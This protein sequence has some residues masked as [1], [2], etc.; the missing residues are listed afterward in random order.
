MRIRYSIGTVIYLAALLLAGCGGGGGGA[1]AAAAPQP[2]TTTVLSGMASK[3]PIRGG[4][5][6][7][8]AVRFGVEDRSAPIGQGRTDDS[9][10]YSIDV[11]SYQG[12]VLVEVTGGMFMDEVSGLPVALNVPLRAAVSN[13]VAG[14]TI[15]AV[16]PLTELAFKRAKGRGSL[17]VAS[18]DDSNAGV[19]AIFDLDDI[20]S[21]LP[22]AGGVSYERKYASACGSISQLVNDNR[23]PDE[24]LGEALPRILTRM[25]EEQEYEGRFSIDSIIMINDSITRF[26]NSGRN[27]SGVAIALLPAPARGVLRMLTAGAPDIIAGIDLT[28][29][30]PAGV[31][32]HADPITGEVAAGVVT[33]SGV[34]SVGGN[35]L[36]SARFTPASGGSPAK[37]Q[38]ILVNVAG[39]GPGEF[40]TIRF[41]LAG[42]ASF[43]AADAFSVTSLFAKGRDGSG[44]AGITAAPAAVAGI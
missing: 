22:V 29:D 32:V 15:V 19:A 33:V 13:A 9:G 26:S 37:L 31:I 6:T 42:G 7:V 8:F 23:Y 44:L 41:D 43:P 25:G 27:E 2:Q 38:V 11:G 16:T 39:F 30:L 21:R 3:G 34:A 36:S 5:V 10:N 12:P 18:I 40:V 24:S 4:T 14:S 1:G 28:L 20:V 35:R 17:T